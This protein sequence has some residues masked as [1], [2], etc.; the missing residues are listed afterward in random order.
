MCSSALPGR[1][2]VHHGDRSQ[3]QATALTQRQGGIDGLAHPQPYPSLAH[4]IEPVP[5]EKLSSHN[6]GHSS[7]AGAE[8]KI[9]WACQPLQRNV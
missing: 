3:V 2:S 8:I 9:I 4:L 7:I 1:E 6:D 5:A